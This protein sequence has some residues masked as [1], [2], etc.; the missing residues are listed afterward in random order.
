MSVYVHLYHG[1]EKA[2]EDLEN[3]G[4]DGPTLGPFE[5]VVWTYGTIRLQSTEDG[6]LWDLPR[7]E[8]MIV[9]RGHYFGDFAIH[10]DEEWALTQDLEPMGA[11]MEHLRGQS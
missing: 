8:D 7:H 6:E 4:F 1:R 11:T 3:W 9:W 2:D 10:T 5:Q